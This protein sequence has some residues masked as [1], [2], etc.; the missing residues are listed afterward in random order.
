VLRSDPLAGLESMASMNR[1]A[2]GTTE[3][4]PRRGVGTGRV[5]TAVRRFGT[6]STVPPMAPSRVAAVRHVTDSMHTTFSQA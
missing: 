5:G 1:S 2:T 4:T 3:R 6:G